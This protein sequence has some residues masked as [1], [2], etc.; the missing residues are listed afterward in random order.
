M[1]WASAFQRGLASAFAEAKAAGIKPVM[2]RAIPFDTTQPSALYI[3][4]RCEAFLATAKQ[5]SA[6]MPRRWRRWRV[7]R[8]RIP[9]QDV[10]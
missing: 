4:E 8:A 9:E 6:A 2:V 10:F 5:R 3:P 7:E 1:R